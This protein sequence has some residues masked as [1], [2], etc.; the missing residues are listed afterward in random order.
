MPPGARHSTNWRKPTR[1]KR[2]KGFSIRSRPI[3]NLPHTQTKNPNTVAKAYQPVRRSPAQ[4]RI[5]VDSVPFLRPSKGVTVSRRA[6]ARRDEEGTRCDATSVKTVAAPAT[7]SGKSSP[8][9]PLA[10]RVG[11]PG[12]LESDVRAVSQETCRHE[13]PIL[14][15]GR[16]G[17]R[18]PGVATDVQP[19]GGNV[20]YGQGLEHPLTNLS[21]SFRGEQRVKPQPLAADSRCT[22]TVRPPAIP[23]EAPA[24]TRDGGDRCRVHLSETQQQDALRSRRNCFFRRAHFSPFWR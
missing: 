10:L 16:A 21:G 7:V 22:S 14:R 4:V 2:P 19:N 20:R 11:A 3:A 24:I 18:L 12:R 6:Q 8:I 5:C 17:E 13:S 23:A 15:A 9:T 1:A